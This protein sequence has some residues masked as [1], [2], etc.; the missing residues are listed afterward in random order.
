MEGDKVDRYV[1]IANQYDSEADALAD[2]DD[3]RKLYTELGID[4][5]FDAAVLTRKADG[6]VEIV[7]RVAE[8]TRHGAASGLIGGMALG[9]ALALFP[10]ITLAG[11]L[12]AGGTLGAGVGAIAGHMVTGISRSDLKDLGELLDNGS[13]GLVVVAATNVGARVE[14]TT[15]RAKNRAKA[16]L[17]AD[18]DA[19]KKELDAV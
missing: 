6:K 10:A 12:L 1:I 18:I 4:R 11:G 17:Q 19:M 13:S 2:F 9:A 16:R 8:Q 5:N 7:K 3:V 15:K 14:A